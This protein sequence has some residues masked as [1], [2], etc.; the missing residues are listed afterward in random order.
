[1]DREGEGLLETN[2]MRPKPEYLVLLAVLVWGCDRNRAADCETGLLTVDGAPVALQ[3]GY[4]EAGNGIYLLDV[5]DRPQRTCDAILP[6]PGETRLNLHFESDPDERRVSIY[7]EAQGEGLGT[8]EVLA[9]GLRLLPPPPTR[10]G[11]ALAMC[12]PPTRLTP[13]RGALAGKDVHI[14]GRF[15]GVMCHDL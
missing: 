11:E 15:S 13:E 2:P 9:P 14:R 8:A 10:K 5:S 7:V 12:V 3:S 1:M 6:D 4:G